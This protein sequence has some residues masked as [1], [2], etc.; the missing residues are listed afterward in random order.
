MSG[1]EIAYGVTSLRAWYAKLGSDPARS[2]G[3]AGAVDPGYAYQP[4]R[5]DYVLQRIDYQPRRISLCV[6]IISL[7]V[8]TVCL[9][10]ANAST[11]VTVSS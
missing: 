8:S 7:R 9:R 6:L 10:I 1:T 3:A 5:V 11:D 4:M 2:R